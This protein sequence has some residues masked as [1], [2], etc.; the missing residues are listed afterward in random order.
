MSIPWTFDAIRRVYR[1]R[2][3]CVQLEAQR[4]PASWWACIRVYGGYLVS[5]QEPLTGTIKEVEALLLRAALRLGIKRVAEGPSY[6]AD[7]A[8]ADLE[9]V[10]QA[11][12][13]P[14]WEEKDEDE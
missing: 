12:Q 4:R 9:R 3:G 11:V 1:A 10:R 6:Y 14:A 8:M 2:L 13:Q 7:A 5:V